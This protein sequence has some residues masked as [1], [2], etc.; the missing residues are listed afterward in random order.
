VLT[1]Y[2]EFEQW[3]SLI[4]ECK[5]Y[6]L[7][8]C[9]VFDN[10]VVFKHVDHPFKVVFGFGTKVQRND[11]LIDIPAH[12]F[13][14]KPFK[15]IEDGNFKTDVLYGIA[16]LPYCLHFFLLYYSF[17]EFFKGA[18][19]ILLEIIGLLHEIVKTTTGGSGKK[20]STNIVLKDERYDFII[21][22]YCLKDCLVDLICI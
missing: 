12:E 8:N 5:T 11:N 16:I 14:F 13:R 15:E 10:D 9:H 21:F 6:T 7:Y 22:R 2:K 3:R 17:Y 20:P 1:R 4:E 19:F 18:L